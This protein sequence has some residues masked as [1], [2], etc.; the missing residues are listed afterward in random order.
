MITI[1]LGAALVVAFAF[2]SP[3]AARAPALR[4]AVE[5]VITSLALTA[6]VIAQAQFVRTRRSRDLV[7]FGAMLTL[8]LIELSSYWVPAAFNARFGGY[9]AAAE[10]WGALFVGVAFVAV[11]QAPADRVISRARRAVAITALVSVFAVGLAGLLGLVLRGELLT[12]SAYPVSGTGHALRHPLGLLL[13]LETA[14][15]FVFAAVAFAR[16]TASDKRSGVLYLLGCAC[17]LLAAA[18]LYSI[19]L[20]WLGPNWIS[21]HEGLRLLAITFAAAAFV[22]QELGRRAEIVRAAAIAERHR[23]AQDLHDGLAQDLAL[24]AAHRQTIAGELGGEHPVTVAVGRAL[25]LSRGTIKELSQ[26]AGSTIQ[27]ALE[28]VAYELSAR[29]AID[30]AVHGDLDHQPALDTREHLA[31]IAREAIANAARHGG[32]TS[33]IVSLKQT[34]NGIALL[35]SDDGCGIGEANGAVIREGF[36]IHSMRERATDLGGRLTVRRSGKSGTEIL[37]VLP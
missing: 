34:G 33:V 7:L 13:T 10:R 36:G 26:P 29:F 24:I 20:N 4:A 31:R 6:A 15:L 22:R 2:V 16:V 25:A 11:S 14:G 37:V 19:P 9:F 18:R 8:A 21:P 35:I 3:V 12:A 28:A 5:T 30:V 17:V 27:D 1:T 32:A 23:V